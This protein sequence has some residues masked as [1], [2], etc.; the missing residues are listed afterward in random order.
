[1]LCVYSADHALH[2]PG[3]EVQLGSQLP[4]YECAPRAEAIR[5]ALAAD[6]VFEFR[7]PEE[8]GVD[9]ITAVHDPGLVHYLETVWSEWR[10]YSETPEFWPDTM[11]HS[12]LREGMGPAPEPKG[13]MGRLG[14][15]CFETM[16]ALTPGTYK[17]VRAA[18]DVALSATDLVL[19][20]ES[21][22]YGLC[23][24]PGH[25][26]VR[27]AFGGYCYL[28]NAAI[29]GEYIVKKTGE[30]VVILDVDYH[31]GNGTQQ[32]FYGRG[33]VLYASIHGD[34]N[35]AY[36]YFAGYADEDGIDDGKGAN[37]NL[38]LPAGATPDA[39]FEALDI[40]LE[41][42]ADFGSATVIVSLGLDTFGADPIAD[43][44][45]TTADLHEMG[46]QVGRLGRNLVVLQEGGYNLEH[47]GANARAWLRGVQDL[48]LDL[49]TL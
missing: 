41:R 24:P 29:A 39:Y 40:A 35:H 48:E 10:K 9:P 14:Y 12:A 8:H 47:L 36:P 22:A 11:L 31:H 32:I 20:G 25:H 26:A 38:P 4:V 3:H 37:L 42:I 30:P 7:A 45:L 6:E 17:S 15:W 1:M 19:N 33:D 2:N 43:F 5:K 46:R 16:T 23:R 13:P 21:V 49:S 18:V 34:P 28:N 44:T 27:A